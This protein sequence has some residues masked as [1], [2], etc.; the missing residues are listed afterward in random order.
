MPDRYGAIAKAYVEQDIQISSWNSYDKIPNPYSLNLYVL[1][2]DG[3]ANFVTANRALKENIRQY[4]RQY[5]MMTDAIN[6]KDPF[7]INV[8][9][10]YDVVI[11]PNYN[12]FEI[13]ARCND[14][15]IELLKNDN[16]EIGAPIQLSTIRTELD[17]IEGVQS[18]NEIEVI[19]LYDT[20]LGYS[21]NVYSIKEA[22]RNGMVYPSLDPCIFEVK[23]PKT[24]IKGRVIDL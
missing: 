16:M 23:Y 7:I 9:I 11:R 15:L 13:L 3:N 10:N 12:S 2:Y 8:G 19:N 14:R 18:V 6:I 5:R 24:D 21:G 22:T 20:K 17:K 4:L 1:S